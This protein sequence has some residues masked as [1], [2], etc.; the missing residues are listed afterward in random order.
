MSNAE[1]T[2]DALLTGFDAYIIGV[3]INLRQ[4]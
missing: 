4:I 1:L 2:A 3:G